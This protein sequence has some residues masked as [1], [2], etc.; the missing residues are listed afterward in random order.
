MGITRNQQSAARI[1]YFDYFCLCYFIY[2]LFGFTF[3]P[4]TIISFF[5]N[6][7]D[8][9]ER[10][11]V[12]D[13]GSSYIR[14]ASFSYMTVA[15]G[16]SISMYMRSVEKVIYPQ[17]ISI[18]SVMLNTGLNFLLIE[19]RY[20]APA[21]GVEGAAIATVISSTVSLVLL[22]SLV[23]LSKQPIFMLRIREFKQITKEFLAHVFKT[24]L[25]VTFNETI[26][27]LGMTMYLIAISYISANAV[28]AMSIANSIMGLTWF[29]NSGI[30]TAAAIMLGNA[31]GRNDL[32]LAKTWGKSSLYYPSLGDLSSVVF[33]FS[34]TDQSLIYSLMHLI[35]LEEVLSLSL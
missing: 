20:G 32:E 22:A 19:G 29:L 16:F 12:S 5:N 35:L 17:I 33:S 30:S 1:L 26:W 13:L 3:F 21:L 10:A 11:I 25:Y 34:L 7:D 4:E 2:I 9:I 23:L 8:P 6:G 31:M 14:I 15:I 24:S 18:L 27:G 28:A